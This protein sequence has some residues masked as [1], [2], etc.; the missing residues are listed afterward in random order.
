MRI[1]VDGHCDTLEKAVDEKLSIDD[2]KLQFNLKDIEREKIIQ[3]MAIY[4][5]PKYCDE[6]EGALN[7]AKEMINKFKIEKSKFDQ[8]IQI[9]SKNDIE[10]FT[11]TKQ[12]VGVILT[13]ENGSAIC[14]KIENVDFY[15]QNGIK[16]M[17]IVWN[18]DNDLG[19]GAHTKNDTGLTDLGKRYIEEL[20]KRNIIIDIS[21]ASEKTFWDTVKYSRKPIVA[22]HSCAYSICPHCRNLKD[23]QIIQISKLNG[24]IGICFASDFLNLKEKAKITDIIKHIKYIANLVGVDCVALGSDFDGV[25]KENIPTDLNGVKDILKLEEALISEG[26]SKKDVRKIMGENWIRFLKMNLK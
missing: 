26:F 1:L 14:G 12:N 5:D 25:S 24:V 20:N 13:I 2:R 17:S 19:C 6:G 22:T 18:E 3:M 8:I 7:R 11:K 10:G 4:I 9:N 16:V 15:A 21:H 23:E